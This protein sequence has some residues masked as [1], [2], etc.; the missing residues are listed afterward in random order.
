MNGRLLPRVWFASLFAVQ[1]S[2]AQLTITSSGQIGIGITSPA[3][4]T[5]LHV[6]HTA[7]V[8]AGYFEGGH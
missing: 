6:Q 4:D 8:R 3:S 7:G 2:W 1:I 5:K